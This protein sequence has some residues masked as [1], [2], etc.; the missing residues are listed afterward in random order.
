[1][2]GGDGDDTVD[3]NQGGDV[4]FLGAGN[5]LF[6]WNPNDGNDTVEGQAG[7]DTL[8]FNG[9][10]V[11]ENIDISANG[12]RVLFLR[13]IANVI[14]DLDDLETIN[15][16]ALRGSDTVLVHDLTGTDVTQVNLNL[17][18][19]GGSGDGEADQVFVDGT[20]GADAL[21][22]SAAG[23][24][25]GVIGL[26][27]SVV[28]SNAD[29]G[30]DVLTLN[31]LGGSD[32]VTVNDLPR[33]PPQ[34]RSISERR[35]RGRSGRPGGR[36]RNGRCRHRDGQRCGRDRKCQRAGAAR[37]HRCRRRADVLTVRARRH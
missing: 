37:R 3:G 32:V 28:L 17:A 7:A 23:G 30:L 22:V 16:R 12:G 29:A 9:A 20:T 35:C 6:L 18:A 34:V 21:T 15:F 2:L 26:A 10:N 33:R 19:S 25:V 4:A 14:L 11:G 27:A 13:D 5:D 8:Q 1:M 24:T 31:A 36:Q